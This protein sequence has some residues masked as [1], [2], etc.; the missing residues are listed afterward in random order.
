VLRVLLRSLAAAA[1]LLVVAGLVWLASAW[2]SSRL[3]GTYSVMDYA[4][5]DF[6]GGSR[7][8]ASHEHDRHGEPG[9][10]SVAKLLGPRKAGRIVRF[11]LT[12][13]H[14]TI[15]L[16]SGRMIDALTFNGTS[17]GPELRVHESDLVEVT[18]V[19]KDLENGVT[20]HW[21][22][23]DVPSGEDGVAGVTQDAIEP[24]QTYTYRFRAEQV[25]TF[26]YH[27]HQDS[28]ADVRR[29]LY[30]AFVIEPDQ[31]APAHA[32]DLVLVAHDFD[33]VQTLNASDGVERRAVAPGTP[34]R[35]RL[36]N[37]DNNPQ[38]FTVG[39]TRFRVGAIDG[40]DLNQPGPLDGTTLA[41]AGGGRYDIVFTMPTAPVTVAVAG[42]AVRL[43]LSNDG[44][45]SPAAAKPG[46]TFDPASY[47][48]PAPTPFDG[49]SRFDRMFKLVIGKKPGFLNGKPG[50]QWTINGHIFPR[51]PMFMVSSGDLVHVT[52]RNKT[53]NVHP[54]HLHGHHVLV[55]SRN[56]VPVT[57]SPWWSD[58]L[59]V[60]A[61][62]RYE[63]A[64]RADNPGIWMDHCHNLR[65]AAGGLTMHVGYIGV[66]TPF[67]TG[68][69]AHNHPE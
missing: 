24:G 32:L 28:A 59:D 58:T 13:E 18:L 17:P 29:G 55:L 8:A 62:E 49:S 67:R 12:A 2:Y 42:T 52:I 11:R 46:P 53:G 35:L 57:G 48:R 6:G 7:P 41:L 39:G 10:T 31:P 64:F 22:G 54:M 21:H 44:Q 40:T 33:G 30:G 45:A 38:R 47:G 3:P 36:I 5:E 15:K 4:V 20:I 23:V 50:R 34:V 65:H 68:T 66:F 26:W 14:A 37:S 19:N 69:P 56:G 63:V 60:Q 25:G 51:I 61:H 1:A 16:A 43:A 27:T 9:G